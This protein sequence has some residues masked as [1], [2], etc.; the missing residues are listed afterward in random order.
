M[1][2]LHRFVDGSSARVRRSVEKLRGSGSLASLVTLT[3]PGFMDSR[4]AA[5]I[6]HGWISACIGNTIG[7]RTA[8]TS[9]AKPALIGDA[10]SPHEI[11][12][13]VDTLHPTQLTRSAACPDCAG[14]PAILRFQSSGVD[15]TDAADMLYESA[16]A[17]ACHRGRDG[18]EDPI[19]D[20]PGT[21]DRGIPSGRQYLRI[22]ADRHPLH[23]LQ[24]VRIRDGAGTAVSSCGRRRSQR[25]RLEN[26]AYT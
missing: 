24:G 10:R 2:P 11:E 15:P 6:R 5:A 13:Y 26:S 14:A 3:Q 7:R 19:S 8:R 9:H 4:R 18:Q 23:G 12:V 17:R 21:G 25:R 20:G 22:L 1:G 16:D